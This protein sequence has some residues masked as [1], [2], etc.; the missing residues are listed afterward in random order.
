VVAIVVAMPMFLD[1]DQ[2]VVIAVSVPA[3]IMIP[4]PV[5]GLDDDDAFLGLRH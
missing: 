1:D 4:I 2:F 5:A 3:T